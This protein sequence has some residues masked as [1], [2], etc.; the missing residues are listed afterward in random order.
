MLIFVTNTPETLKFFKNLAVIHNV[1]Q[2]VVIRK[3]KMDNK[4][5]WLKFSNNELKKL[6]LKQGV[7]RSDIAQN[8]QGLFD[9]YD[10]NR[11]GL[12]EN[13]ELGSIFQ[14]ISEHAGADNTFD[15]NENVNLS[16]IFSTMGFEKANMQ[17]FIAAIDAVD[18]NILDYTESE[19][20]DGGHKIITK[21]TDG[22]T[23]TR[24][25]Y[26]DGEIKYIK[27]EYPVK[28]NHYY[29][30][31]NDSSIICSP[32]EISKE[33]YDVLL[34]NLEEITPSS[35]ILD[36]SLANINLQF[37][38]TPYDL[39][40]IETN[41]METDFKLSNRAQL[42]I[43]TR[44]SV[45]N[46]FIDSYSYVQEQIDSLGWLD[47][48]GAVLDTAWEETTNFAENCWNQVFNDKEWRNVDNFYDQRED[49]NSVG[50]SVAF[51][52]KD[53]NIIRARAEMGDQE[54]YFDL[55]EASFSTATGNN[56]DN[57]KAFEF[58]E[59]AVQ[60]QAVSALEMR[61]EYLEKAR[62]A[63]RPS[64]MED[65]P[66]YYDYLIM[67]YGANGDTV[68]YLLE[69]QKKYK[70]NAVVCDNNSHDL[71]NPE[72][73]YWEY[74][75][76]DQLIQEAEEQLD[77]ALRKR[78]FVPV[79]LE[80][81]STAFRTKVSN[82]KYSVSSLRNEYCN[83]YKDLYNTDIVPDEVLENVNDAKTIG[84]F[85]K[86]GIII[87]IQVLIT[88]GLGS[89]GVSGATGTAST[90]TTGGRM[91]QCLN[92]LVNRYGQAAVRQSIRFSMATGAIAMDVGLTLLNQL[93]DNRPGIE[94]DELIDTAL[95][96]A[97]YIYFGAY[98]AGPVAERFA[99]CI[100][101]S[102]VLNNI[103]ARGTKVVNGSTTTT[104][105]SGKTLLE[106][107]KRVG[108]GTTTFA[109][110]AVRFGTNV[111]MF[112]GLELATSDVN[113]FDAFTQQGST[114]A[115]LEVM[116][117]IFAYMLGVNAHAAPN[118]MKI[119]DPKME[120]A[121]KKSGVE[122]WNIQ[123]HVS[124]D[125][126]GNTSTTYTIDIAGVPYGKEFKS[127]EQLVTEMVGRV[128]QV[129]E[130]MNVLDITT[131]EDMNNLGSKYRQKAKE[132]HPDKF[133][134]DNNAA[135][136]AMQKVNEAKALLE[137]CNKIEQ[138]VS[139][140]NN[141]AATDGTQTV[142]SRP[143][144][145]LEAAPDTSNRPVEQSTSQSPE[146]RLEESSTRRANTENTVKRTQMTE[147]DVVANLNRLVNED[148]LAGLGLSDSE[149]SSLRER[150]DVLAMIYV[151]KQSGEEISAG[152]IREV[153]SS[154]DRITSDDFCKN[155]EAI[156]EKSNGSPEL[157]RTL[158]ET[159]A[160]A[161]QTQIDAILSLEL[162]E[163]V[164]ISREVTKLDYIPR[165]E[166]EADYSTLFDLR[167]ENGD[168]RFSRSDIDAIKDAGIDPNDSVKLDAYY[169]IKTELNGFVPGI[170]ELVKSDANI[171][172][173]ITLLK[174]NSRLSLQRIV[175]LSKTEN[176][177]NTVKL[178]N[179]QRFSV[180]T[181]LEL[182]KQEDVSLYV[183][184]AEIQ[185]KNDYDTAEHLS[186]SQIIDL[187]NNGI[188]KENFERYLAIRNVNNIEKTAFSCE[189]MIFLAENNIDPSIC[190]SLLET[191]YRG[192]HII[193]FVRENIDLDK[194]YQTISITRT[195][196]SGNKVR[197]FD[198]GQAKS[199]CQ[200]DLDLNF[201]NECL[202]K[203]NIDSDLYRYTARDVL[204][205]AEAYKIAP[206]FTRECMEKKNIDSDLYRYTARD[207]LDLAKAYEMAP[208]FTRECIEK[209]YLGLDIDIYRFEAHEVAE[210]VK[211]YKIDPSFVQQ[212]IAA[213][214]NENMGNTTFVTDKYSSWEICNLVEISTFDKDLA[215]YI[216]NN[217]T[218]NIASVRNC[219]TNE[220][221]NLLKNI[222]YTEPDLKVNVGTL[223][224]TINTI[225]NKNLGELT[226]S[227]LIGLYHNLSYLNELYLKNAE[228]DVGFNIEEQ[229]GS[230]VSHLGEVKPTINTDNVAQS[231]FL[232]SL[233]QTDSAARNNGTT[234]IET[235][236]A[237][238]DFTRFSDGIPL[239]Y[240]RA[241]FT[242]NIEAI[243]QNLTPSEQSIVLEHFGLVRGESGFDGLPNNRNFDNTTVRAEVIE[244]ANLVQQ[245]I[246]NFT[247]NNSVSTGEPS[248]DRI[249]N[250]IIQGFPEFTFIV[251]KQQ[252]GT[253]QYSLDIHTLKVLQSAM[254][255]PKYQTLSNEDKI[256]LKTA[257]LLHDLGKKGG[258]V[259]NGH[260]SVS[261][262]YARSILAKFH[263]PK[264]VEARILDVVNNHH[265]FENYNK[266]NASAEEIIVLAHTPNDLAIYEIMGKADLRNVSVN[267]HH[268]IM[269]TT[270]EAEFDIKMQEKYATLETTLNE[271]YKRSNLI[272]S[273]RFLSPSQMT[274]GHGFPIE[275][276]ILDGQEREFR[277]LNLNELS[278]EASLHEY[279]FA[280]GVT[281]SNVRFVVH[282][283]EGVRCLETTNILLNN[284][285]NYTTWSTSIISSTH[286]NTYGNRSTGYILDVN[287]P[288]IAIANR[289]NLSSGYQKNLSS[290]QDQFFRDDEVRNSFSTSLKMCLNQC[291]YDLTDSQYSKLTQELSSI[292]NLMQINQDIQIDNLT[293]K[294]SDLR[295]AIESAN[296]QLLTGFGHN[297]IV[298]INPRV[299]G[300]Y[301]KVDNFSQVPPEVLRIAVRDNLPIIIMK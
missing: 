204:D 108:N 156:V 112:T 176:I 234:S 235:A 31:Y 97:K 284:P 292:T 169:R 172:N 288:D 267:F 185:F 174:T 84:G 228:L 33:E 150:P 286:T 192:D 130:A 57:Q 11:D 126:N 75:F 240:T 58:D 62:D 91:T 224:N 68:N 85:V 139:A 280:S 161:N 211:A 277:V 64:V 254:N 65:E 87:L 138:A 198:D 257:I 144:E 59:L 50:A 225:N 223:L 253:H 103:F 96:S 29:V 195:N 279:G 35:T 247:T 281:K 131:P 121:L 105:V 45:V 55:L 46:H 241:D 19:M 230:V 122:N 206:E 188:S 261:A 182:S 297:E 12:L 250:D 270:S 299:R 98:V 135:N 54:A 147:S 282:M 256:V 6:D 15:V 148:T 124:T 79:E 210:L 272:Y 83:A 233:F 129:Y 66:T 184:L 128:S 243:L 219:I 285:L 246:T 266:E 82:E 212:C 278:S 143:V 136:E 104:T 196:E 258:V 151:Y 28:E 27:R 193:S 4:D 18:E 237:N 127:S 215:I 26:P 268:N 2:V 152:D 17:E 1:I 49:F 221:I 100:N 114:F 60:Y 227:E 107:M 41:H 22:S 229:I 71:R 179:T 32:Q 175:E 173:A 95:N 164:D 61:L 165:N 260:Y 115:I 134:G 232:R 76:I 36:S 137:D 216:F 101:G 265:W 301:V 34:A 53:M 20:S 16:N 200:K 213:T 269:K 171:D 205:L 300:I 209:K 14:T 120:L 276:T 116:N 158:A 166:G 202:E 86:M 155:I 89:A 238:F 109:S 162:D 190:K 145:Y 77:Y 287:S 159:L 255:D 70:E 56:Y 113:P 214:K 191:N 81:G 177:E 289:E 293:I 43:Y 63:I 252:H 39:S 259:D 178:V 186:E 24:A 94:T 80:D 167:N 180:E 298:T 183:E 99:G 290:L 208:E 239:S 123:E 194:F 294:A 296:N 3:K 275:R 181:M 93:T 102:R 220:N 117:N 203:K 125:A 187:V 40:C 44:E 295:Y 157:S 119:L 74:G 218:V 5:L 30:R 146:V 25:Y 111:T 48:A 142:I 189:Q 262:T 226:T 47:Y 23:E 8:L 73:C 236:F 244:A 52:E 51:L 78:V 163:N 110:G 132:C 168:Y 9:L 13:R 140:H 141:M 222:I 197:V 207:V 248:V 263:F 69:E 264:R 149:I 67:A 21:Y 283:T 291:G 10:I 199:I 118:K 38:T 90:A 245:E 160:E 88:K 72:T 201:I 170:T 273:T 153:L 271:L 106:G 154:P 217:S 42:D 37:Q 242:S 249:L 274:T 251:G 92:T 7:R 133:G 231:N